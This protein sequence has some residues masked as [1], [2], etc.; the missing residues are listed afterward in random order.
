MPG[1]RLLHS[2][3]GENADGVDR[4]GELSEAEAP[5][6]D[7]LPDAYI[8]DEALERAQA[9]ARQLAQEAG[10]DWDALGV[11]EKARFIGLS[12]VELPAVPDFHLNGEGYGHIARLAYPRMQAA[13]MVP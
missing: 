5:P 10:E 1:V 3:H 4:Q 8:A 13:G 9:R 11:A 2:V 6:P 7:F 12:G